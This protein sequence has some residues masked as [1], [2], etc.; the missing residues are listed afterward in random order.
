VIIALLGTLVGL[1]ISVL[2]GWALVEA[3]S[4]EGIE[5][6]DIPVAQMVAIVVLSAVAGV[7]AG[8]LPA[9]RAARLDVLH[10]ISHE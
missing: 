8:I 7:V 1:A 10:A 5:V 9:R 2:F 3:L 6:F 4:D